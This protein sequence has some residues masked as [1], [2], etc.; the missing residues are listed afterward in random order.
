M[1][2]NFDELLN[3]FSAL[4]A[5][6]FDN[7]AE[8]LEK[9]RHL[10]EELMTHSHPEMGILA[11]F[12]VMERMPDT[13]MGTPG[14][15]VHTLEKMRGYYEPEL[16]ESI[17]RQPS[18]LSVWMVNRIMNGTNDV[19]QLQAYLAVLQIAANHLNAPESVRSVAEHFIERQ[20][21]RVKIV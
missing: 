10:T 6:D 14:P 1:P 13:E 12:L 17:K 11:L 2:R 18:N 19:K 20:S 21:R 3:D 5:S 4:K 15:L 7:E 16:I 8:G 9:L